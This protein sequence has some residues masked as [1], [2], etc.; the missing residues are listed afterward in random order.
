MKRS[1]V[2]LTGLLCA[3]A[4]TVGAAEAKKSK[5]ALTDDQKTLQ[6]QMLEKYDANKDG[7]LDKEERAK[8]T[9]GEKKKWQE[10]F[11]QK[12][13]PAKEETKSSE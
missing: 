10:T 4:L 7:K 11:G 2:T 1:L 6:K 9:K 12:K 8:M 5:K 13:K 3:L